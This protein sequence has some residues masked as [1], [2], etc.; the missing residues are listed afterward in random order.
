ERLAHIAVM[1]GKV[2]SNVPE[3]HAGDIGTVAK[4]KETL[5]G[6]TL[7]DKPAAILYPAVQL[8]E[9]AISFA[10]APNSR[11]D[12]DRLGA[13]LH[14]ILERDSSL[15]FFRESEEEGFPLG[16]GGQQDCESNVPRPKK[17]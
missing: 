9:P 10:I 15:R 8:P 17:R 5:T 6:D 14:K 2:A 11:G 12:E 13:A 4:L 7:G 1:Q 3:F 16:R